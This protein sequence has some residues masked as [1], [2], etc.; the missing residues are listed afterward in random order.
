MSE[1]VE[2]SEGCRSCGYSEA[3]RLA[4]VPNPICTECGF[5][6]GTE[7]ELSSLSRED[8]SDNSE[9]QILWKNYH[10][11]TNSTEKQIAVALE[12]VEQIGDELGLSSELRE[13]AAEVYAKA[14]I[15]TLTDGRSTELVIAAAVCIASREV[16]SPKTIPIVAR[17]AD[18]DTAK[19]KRTVRVFQRELNRGFSG[20]SA[21][22]YVSSMSD[23]AGLKSRGDKTAKSLI[24]EYE[25]RERTTGLNPA[26]IAGAA[27]YIVSEGNITQRE[28][29]TLTGLSKETIRIRVAE[30]R[31]VDAR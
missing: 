14:S 16:S 18:I 2:I 7:I 17:A 24:K 23:D 12:D 3:E 31:E 29:A 5:V 10:S 19:L 13:Q 25:K 20:L 1:I 27:I 15:E 4:E 9:S 22:E 21:T 8:D 11:V 6:V 26:G 30:L 28:I